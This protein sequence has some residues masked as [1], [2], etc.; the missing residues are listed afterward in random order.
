M[1][2]G[3]AVIGLEGRWFWWDEAEQPQLR[4]AF[5]GEFQQYL[6]DGY[7]LLRFESNALFDGLHEVVHLDRIA[8]EH[9]A[10]FDSEQ[11]AESGTEWH[12]WMRLVRGSQVRDSR[13]VR[14]RMAG[15]WLSRSCPTR[16][17]Y[18]TR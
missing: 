8:N 5:T 18:R 1:V 10:I 9:W 4:K 3:G 11:K 16:R 13:P 6:G 12:Y 15:Y 14:V 7:Y 2:V 17:S